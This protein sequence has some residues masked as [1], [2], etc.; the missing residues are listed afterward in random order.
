MLAIQFVLCGDNRSHY[1]FRTFRI[2]LDGAGGLFWSNELG[3]EDLATG[4]AY[5][6]WIGVGIINAPLLEPHQ[7]YAHPSLFISPSTLVHV[8]YGFYPGASS[9][10]HF[11]D[12][13]TKI[14]KFEH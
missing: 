5:M 7:V 11:S 6:L 2:F 8:F 10:T 14:R 12:T 9:L 1:R 13:E 3:Q 4:A